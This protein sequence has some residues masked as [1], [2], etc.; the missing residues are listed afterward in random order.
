MKVK[1]IMVAAV[2]CASVGVTGVASA[3]HGEA[4]RFEVC[5][6]AWVRNEP[7]NYATVIGTLTRPQTF[8]V[9]QDSKNGYDYGYAYG[10]VD[11]FGYI[12]DSDLC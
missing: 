3:D 11:K 12:P 1:A 9:K 6:S 4:G 2:A 8:E 10:N 7:S 5:S